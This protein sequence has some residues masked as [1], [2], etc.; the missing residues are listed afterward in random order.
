MIC[1]DI[2]IGKEREGDF[3]ESWNIE[4][5]KLEGPDRNK[6]AWLTDEIYINE[7]QT[8]ACLVYSIA[9]TSMGSYSGKLAIFM[10][11]ENPR[12]VFD[13]SRIICFGMKEHVVY[14]DGGRKVVVRTKIYDSRTNKVYT[15]FLVI[16]IQANLFSYI[17]ITN[18]CHYK[19]KII[20]DDSIQLIEQY[21]D[22]N[23]PSMDKSIISIKVLSGQMLIA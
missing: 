17:P 4:I 14:F 16:D 2:K 23:L 20:D 12:L 15:P 10:D 8:I 3:L 19:L 1:L 13:T 5:D 18:G 9:E 7:D 22:S 21:K 11:K 6:W